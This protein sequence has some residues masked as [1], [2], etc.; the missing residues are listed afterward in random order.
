[1]AQAKFEGGF[2]RESEL[3]SSAYLTRA[4]DSYLDIED[5]LPMWAERLYGEMASHATLNLN[6]AMEAAL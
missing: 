2:K 1:M 4:F 5:E 3:T 6:V